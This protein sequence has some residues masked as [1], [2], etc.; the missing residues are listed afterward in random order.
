MIEKIGRKSGENRAK[1]GRKLGENLIS[2]GP[3]PGRYRKVSGPHLFDGET[4]YR[5]RAERV[6]L[7]GRSAIR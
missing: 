4:H 5:W 1:I 7:D 2:L 3:R 6:S